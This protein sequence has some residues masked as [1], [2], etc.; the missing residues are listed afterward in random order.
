MEAL[1]LLGMI[2][3]IVGAFFYIYLIRKCVKS[4][5][6]CWSVQA[7]CPS[8]WNEWRGS[9]YKATEEPKS[10]SEA[11]DECKMVGGA[12]ATPNSLEEM[13]YLLSLTQN[14]F[15]I[16][17]KHDSSKGKLYEKT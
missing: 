17:C 14:G 13:D 5:R 11:Q 16:N 8:D 7:V 1:H 3:I 10:L 15:W 4:R 6:D 9:C 12:M 2:I